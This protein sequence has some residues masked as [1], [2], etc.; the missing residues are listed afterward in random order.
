M[1]W[2]EISGNWVYIP[3]RPQAIVHFLGGAFVAAAPHITYKLLLEDLAKKGYAIVATPFINTFDHTAIAGSVYDSFEATL[4]TL[5]RRQ[6]LPSGYLPIYGMGHSMGC[7]LHLMIGSMYEV[8][9]AGNILISFNNFA[10]RDALPLFDRVPTELNIE[11]TP[12]PQ[13]TLDLIAKYYDVR[14]NLIVKFNNDTLDQSYTIGNTLEN[15]FP[16]MISRLTLNGNHLTPLGQ[17]FQLQISPNV[18]TPFDAIGQWFKQEIHRDLHQ[19]KR[20][21]LRWLNPGLMQN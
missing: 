9:R 20:E 10:A 2:Q 4:E 13:A 8:E 7:K 6:R 17:D 1:D 3:P 14:R 15:I 11:F 16:G 18:F 5:E 19:L 12:S 21:M